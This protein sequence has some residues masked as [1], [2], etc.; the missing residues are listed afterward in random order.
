MTKYT[1]LVV[2]LGKR[3]K[4]HATH[5]NANPEFEVVGLCDMVPAQLTVSRPPSATRRPGPTPPPWPGS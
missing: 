4:H 5:F 1:V 2:G 3:G